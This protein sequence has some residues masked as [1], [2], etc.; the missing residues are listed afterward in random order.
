MEVWITSLSSSWTAFVL[1]NWTDSFNRGQICIRNCF[2]SGKLWS[3]SKI[4]MWKFGMQCHFQQKKPTACSLLSIISTNRYLYHVEMS[5]RERERSY[6]ICNSLNLTDR[7]FDRAQRI[8]SQKWPRP[9]RFDI[10]SFPIHPQQ[11][12]W[13]EVF[14]SR[15][16]HPV[17]SN[18]KMGSWERRR[19]LLV[20]IA[21]V[22]F[23]YL[24]DIQRRRS[25]LN[26]VNINV[27]ICQSFCKNLP[28]VKGMLLRLLDAM[29]T[30]GRFWYKETP[31]QRLRICASPNDSQKFST[32]SWQ[33]KIASTLQTRKII[34]EQ[35]P[36][37]VA[38]A[39]EFMRVSAFQFHT[40]IDWNGMEWNTTQQ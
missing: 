18:H 14:R 11:L 30:M 40:T 17:R 38:Q 31:R 19:M 20:L 10:S 23:L 13:C 28:A 12:S 37:S 6:R 35:I 7:S 25:F 24:T 9:Y 32:T 8:Q 27:H 39:I 36:C 4:L 33:Q 2:D 3:K 22:R 15:F 16:L 21:G 29:L 1:I 5:K 34:Y 26:R